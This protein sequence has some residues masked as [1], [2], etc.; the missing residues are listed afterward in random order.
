[1]R[2]AGT[3]GPG[4]LGIGLTVEY[5][6]KTDPK[7]RENNIFRSGPDRIS[8]LSQFGSKSCAWLVPTA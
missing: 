4:L 2:T 8:T 6:A 7:N 5:L 1:M 3:R